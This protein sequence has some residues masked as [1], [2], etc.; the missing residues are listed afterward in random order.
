MGQ[1][2]NKALIGKRMKEWLQTMGHMA[3]EIFSDKNR[4]VE[5]GCLTKVL[6]YNVLRQTR[7]NGAIC[8]VDA[9]NCYDRVAH[10]IVS[11]IFQAYDIPLTAAQTM[12][13]AIQEMKFFLHT[14]FGDSKGFLGATIEIKNTRTV[15]RKWSGASGLG[16]GEYHNP[17]G[18]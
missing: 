1:M 16:G 4:T 13:K 18:T 12:L 7:K 9:D 8:S 6:F 2:H 3:E 15:P 17:L 10:A 11:L 5:E 14:A